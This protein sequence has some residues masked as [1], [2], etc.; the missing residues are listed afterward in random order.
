MSYSS[1]TTRPQTALGF[2][3]RTN[4]NSGRITSIQN[5]LNALQEL[6]LTKI[7]NYKDSVWYKYD[8]KKR[9]R[10]RNS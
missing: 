6:E 7:E 8:Y 4:Y 3:Q 10:V 9:S 2:L 5:N 1:T